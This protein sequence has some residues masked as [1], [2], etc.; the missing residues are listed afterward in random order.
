MPEFAHSFEHFEI[1]LFIIH[2]SRSHV[3]VT[4]C[5]DSFSLQYVISEVTQLAVALSINTRASISEFCSRKA[6]QPHA[7][8]VVMFEFRDM[9]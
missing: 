1:P 8:Y 4:T 2:Y 3:L 6:Q 5:D 9:L 7:G